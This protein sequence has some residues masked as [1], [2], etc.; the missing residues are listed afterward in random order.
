MTTEGRNFGKI[1][2]PLKILHPFW[3]SGRGSIGSNRGTDRRSCLKWRDERA[4]FDQSCRTGHKGVIP[5][6]PRRIS[7]SPYL[8]RSDLDG[9][10]PGRMRDP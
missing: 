2:H 9:N 1:P 3:N 8:L 6:N 4:S 5:H 7:S 10:L